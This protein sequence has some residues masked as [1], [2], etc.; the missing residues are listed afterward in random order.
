MAV[1]T[2]PVPKESCSDTIT[3]SLKECPQTALLIFHSTLISLWSL[4]HSVHVHV[5][6]QDLL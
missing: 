3:Q 4:S 2:L 5:K 6:N 1:D